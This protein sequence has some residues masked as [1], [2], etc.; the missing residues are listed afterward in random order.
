MLDEIGIYNRVL[1]PDEIA[2]IV[3]ARGAGQCAEPPVIITQPQ[4]QMVNLGDTAVFSVTAE[5]TP[6]LHYQWFLDGSAI[7]G[8]T[9]PILTLT[10]AQTN[11]SGIYS[12]T[13]SNMLGVAVSS[14]AVLRVNRPPIADASATAPLAI[15]CN[16]SN[17]TVILDGARSSDSDGDTLRF[18][19]FITGS[20]SALATGMVAEV[21][22][23]PG[24]NSITLQVSDGC[25]TSEQTI[26]VE[27]ITTAQA[28]QRLIDR[29]D[30]TVDKPQPLTAI[31]NTALNALSHD[32]CVSAIAE[33]RAF[34]VVVRAQ[35]S[36]HNQALAAS[37]SAAAETIIQAIESCCEGH[38]HEHVFPTIHCGHGRVH[39]EF[40]ATPGR[41]Y[42]VEASDD[43]VHWEKVGVA[44]DLNDGN[45]EFDDSHSLQQ[46][47]RFYRI[48]PPQ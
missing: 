31:L 21:V 32:H 6:V 19:W 44:T 25:A 34:Q 48:V 18:A 24:T 42:L 4:S 17:A 1:S 16:N 13:A 35:V 22:L 30:A 20:N 12:V 3:A 8:A 41:S 33:L 40:A 28:V 11:Q 43:L 10:G 14:N 23:P 26:S 27:V 15:S 46:P 37:L 36:G 47:T 39:L 7:N 9:D 29:V 2:A 45:F 5:G 38:G